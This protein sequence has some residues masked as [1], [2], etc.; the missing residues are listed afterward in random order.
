M[1]R[2]PCPCIDKELQFSQ[3]YTPRYPRRSL[4]AEKT[5]YFRLEER[6]FQKYN[7]VK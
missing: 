6:Y 3:S 2:I 4:F 7:D 5:I 1:A